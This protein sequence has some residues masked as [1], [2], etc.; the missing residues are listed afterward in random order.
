M[1]TRQELDAQ[2]D[3]LQEALPQLATDEDADFDYLDF[4]ARAE[5]LLHC[6]TSADQEHVRA[7]VDGMLNAAGLV[8]GVPRQ[9]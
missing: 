9:R 2:L 3:A 8:P 5:A 1:P 6:A 4:Q 7:R